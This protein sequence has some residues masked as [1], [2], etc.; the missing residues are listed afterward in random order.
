V[1]RQQSIVHLTL[2]LRVSANFR[3]L[4]ECDAIIA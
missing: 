2:K 4:E 1:L 3:K